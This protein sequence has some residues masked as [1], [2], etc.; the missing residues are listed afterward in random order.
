[1]FYLV[2]EGENT[3]KFY[4]ESFSVPGVLK[5]DYKHYKLS[6]RQ[7]VEK[8]IANSEGKSYTEVWVVFDLDYNPARG[9]EQYA[10]FAD[11][12]QYAKKHG[13][14]VAYSIDSFEIW[15]RL[16]YENVTT[17]IAR[18]QLY[19]DLSQRW[20]T[21]YEQFGKEAASALD[22]ANRLEEDPSASR[23]EAINRAKSLHDEYQDYPYK[24]QPSITTVYR[25]VHNLITRE[26]K[27]RYE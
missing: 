5:V 7:L 11:A 21:D 19:A 2:G 13:V 1:M 22:I 23:E 27:E 8:A 10:E 3:E 15:F 12:I 24:D 14:K 20:E 17:R 18:Q 26:K 4:F 9:D 16:H 25:L 6:T